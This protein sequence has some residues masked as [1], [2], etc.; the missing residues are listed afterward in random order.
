[1]EAETGVLLADF[2]ETCVDELAD[3][4]FKLAKYLKSSIKIIKAGA[5]VLKG[6]DNSAIDKFKSE[7][8][9]DLKTL[10]QSA[11][12]DSNHLKA[13]LQSTKLFLNENHSMLDIYKDSEA[14]IKHLYN[15]SNIPFESK[16]PQTFVQIIIKNIGKLVPQEEWNQATYDALQEDLVITKELSEKHDRTE[17]K[18]ED[19]YANTVLIKEFLM[20]QP[21]NPI[22]KI[23][24]QSDNQY[25]MDKYEYD[26]SRENSNPMSSNLFL[27]RER[28]ISL[29]SV[30]VD[31]VSYDQC[32]IFETIISWINNEPIDPRGNFTESAAKL[33][34]IYGA[35]GVGKSSL[36]SKI[37][38]ENI[39][40]MG[41]TIAIALR[42]YIDKV[43]SDYP[44]EA[45]KNIIGVSD[46][47]YLLNKIIILDG[48]DE[49]CVLDPQFDGNRFLTELSE[50]IPQEIRVLVTSRESNMYFDRVIDRQGYIVVKNLY[51]KKEQAAAWCEKYAQIRQDDIINKWVSTFFKQLESFD[52]SLCEIFCIPIILYIACHEN[53]PLSEYTS[54]GEIYE[55]SFRSIAHREYNTIVSPRSTKNTDETDFNILWELLKELSFQMLLCNK[56][57][58]E[59]GD[60]II[61][62]AIQAA[63]RKNKEE[64]G[65]NT[66]KMYLQHL[67]AVFL[68]SSQNRQGIEFAHKSV[69]EFFSAI[70]IYEDYLSQIDSS[71]DYKTVWFNTVE[72]FRYVDIPEEVFAYIESFVKRDQYNESGTIDYSVFMKHY[73]TGMASGEIL[74][75]LSQSPQYE[76]LL[77]LP[78]F[79]MAHVFRNITWLITIISS[80]KGIK[81]DVSYSI[82]DYIYGSYLFNFHGWNKSNVHLD[83]T[84]LAG[85]QFVST[86]LQN[87][88]I[89]HTYCVKSYFMNANM[90]G[91]DLTHSFFGECALSNTNLGH[92]HLAEVQ[93][94][95]IYAIDVDFSHSYMVESNFAAAH[96]EGCSFESANL[97]M[98]FL[99][100]ASFSNVNFSSA[101]LCGANLYDI[102]F[103][104]NTIWHNALYCLSEGCLTIFPHNFNPQEHG[105]IEVD[106]EGNLVITQEREGLE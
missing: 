39:L 66:M 11:H 55:K 23:H 97:S 36:V 22:A 81:H 99:K 25:Y 8:K 4:D 45:V 38:S 73:N 42:K 100:G 92:S 102:R 40:G 56:I 95:G 83:C 14:F 3:S 94:G 72:P 47:S 53:I 32:S 67:P 85:A 84:F 61:N 88:D 31:P 86:E 44:W 77:P 54:R 35:A 7:L 96:F 60:S 74:L 90:L 62:A 80:L 59:V 30:Y 63:I 43:S 49:V 15:S 76:M 16:L 71:A 106:A 103:D 65:F 68:F 34:L 37:V 79:Q 33:M 93:M 105:M 57:E 28:Y 87:A 21:D 1:M 24:M 19:M 13:I 89:S 9:K 46:E 2:I 10:E 48:L 17:Q 51:W 104:K 20:P 69:A 5:D 82:R 52:S 27:E 29:K 91:A 75:R 64:Y 101:N 6:E 18:I 70:K 50:S 41:R 58:E 26:R 12:V 98:A 78:N